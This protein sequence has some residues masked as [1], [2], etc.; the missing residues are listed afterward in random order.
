MDKQGIVIFPD[1]EVL[2]FGEH[3]YMD[4]PKY[5]TS[6][7]HEESFKNEILSSF[8]FRLLGLEYNHEYNLY[9]N[10]IN[11][12]LEG[13]LFIFNNTE[14]K[15]S[16]VTSLCYMPVNPTDEQKNSLKETDYDKVFE[17]NKIYEFNSDDFDDY[18]GYE[19]FEDYLNSKSIKK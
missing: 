6:P 9:K 7:G 19:S 2:P 18:Q 10:A 8:S 15:D 11:L 16:K 17:V 12:S 1:G 5:L 3:V 4:E 13:L 14:T